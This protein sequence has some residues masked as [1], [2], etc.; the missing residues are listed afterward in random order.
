MANDVYDPLGS[1]FLFDFDPVEAGLNVVPC[2]DRPDKP[3]EL[4]D[5]DLKWLKSMSV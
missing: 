1:C 5:E 2:N 3:L 4:N